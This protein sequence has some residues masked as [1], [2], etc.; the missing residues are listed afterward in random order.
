MVTSRL[1][2][3]PLRIIPSPRDCLAEVRRKS[4]AT[5]ENID[6]LPE[7]KPGAIYVGQPIVGVPASACCVHAY[8]ALSIPGKIMIEMRI[9]FG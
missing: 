9:G 5:S 8:A 1:D 7:A 2:T 4:P 6:S 3:S